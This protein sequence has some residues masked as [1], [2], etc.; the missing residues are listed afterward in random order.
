MFADASLFETA[1][2]KLF[3]GEE[4]YR[5]LETANLKKGGRLVTT[6]IRY[7]LDYDTNL[8]T[9]FFEYKD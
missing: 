9:I 3:K 8:I 1:A 6:S 2:Q 4:I 7:S 5:S